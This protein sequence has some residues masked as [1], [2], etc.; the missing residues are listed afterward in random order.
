[1]YSIVIQHR[2]A[3]FLNSKCFSSFKH[4]ISGILTLSWL[5]SVVHEQ[6]I[7][8]VYLEH[9]SN[10]CSLSSSAVCHLHEHHDLFLRIVYCLRFSYPRIV[11]EWYFVAGMILWFLVFCQEQLLKRA[12]PW[13]C[14]KSMHFGLFPTYPNGSFLPPPPTMAWSY[15]EFIV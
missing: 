4:N 6:G 13:L 10:F 8:S 1:M 2:L 15:W 7:A 11:L 14:M 9:A 3:V 12:W 5:L